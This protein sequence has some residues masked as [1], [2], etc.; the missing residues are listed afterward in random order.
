MDQG[1][2]L[3]YRAVY[4]D[5][6]TVEGVVLARYVDYVLE[7]GDGAEALELPPQDDPRWRSDPAYA[8][9]LDEQGRLRMT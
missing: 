5:I 3:G 8:R 9:L 2:R 1:R 6:M 7:A 4:T